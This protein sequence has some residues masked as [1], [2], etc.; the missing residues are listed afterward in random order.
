MLLAGGDAQFGH[1]QVITSEMS[2]A[3]AQSKEAAVYGPAVTNG[4]TGIRG[5]TGIGA[6]DTGTTAPTYSLM[7]GIILSRANL[8]LPV[9]M[10]KWLL[11]PTWQ[12]Q[13]SETQK[14]AN[15]GNTVLA[16][17]NPGANGA[18]GDPGMEI[19]PSGEVCGY[20]AYMSTHVP[21]ETSGDTY[22]YFGLWQYVWC[23]DYSTAFLTIDDISQAISGQT[24]I[25]VN[26]YH[27]VAVRFPAAFYVETWDSIT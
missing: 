25:T 18:G 13:L 9:G 11:S 17:V 20:P 6:H 26:S 2:R 7:N 19:G 22:A 12:R 3:L 21:V 14:F 27:D 16:F 24:R 10:G 23:I 5:T 1:Q 8:H 15:A 4:P